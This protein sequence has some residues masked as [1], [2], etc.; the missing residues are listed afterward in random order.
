MIK[1][2]IY[3]MRCV[4]VCQDSATPSA[5]HLHSELTDGCLRWEIYACEYYIIKDNDITDAI[6]KVS[7]EWKFE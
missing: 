5:R 7:T 1:G 6:I 4:C 2:E 3:C